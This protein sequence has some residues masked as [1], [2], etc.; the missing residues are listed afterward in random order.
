CPPCGLNKMAGQLRKTKEQFIKEARITHGNKYDYSNINYINDS[1][2]IE[3]VCLRHGIF[4]Q[5]A[6]NHIRGNGCP[7]CTLTPQ[8]KQELT[9]TFELIQFFPDINPKG[10]KIKIDGKM[11][12]IDIY[13]PELKLGIEFDGNYWHKDKEALDK[14]KTEKLEGEGF[15]IF[16]VREEPLKRI[17]EDDIMSSRPFNGKQITNDILTQIMNRYT[18]NNMKINQIKSYIASKGLQNEKGLDKYI[19][20]ILNEKAEKKK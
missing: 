11:K 7:Y 2:E 1:S 17:F 12:S 5:I 6:G 15:E 10:F 13:I 16:R 14:L 18:L 19:E 4:P 9:I 20:T 3:I 8:S